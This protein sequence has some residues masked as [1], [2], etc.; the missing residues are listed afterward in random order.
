VFWAK[1]EYNS[2]WVKQLRGD[3][4]KAAITKRIEG[5]INAT[6]GQ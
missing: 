5:V 4:M 3:D 1:E 6:K 2:E